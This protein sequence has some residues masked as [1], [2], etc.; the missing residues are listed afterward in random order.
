M[1][2]SVGYHIKDDIKTTAFSAIYKLFQ[3][4]VQYGPIYKMSAQD[5]SNFLFTRI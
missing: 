2:A 3:K 4:C 5:I 1:N